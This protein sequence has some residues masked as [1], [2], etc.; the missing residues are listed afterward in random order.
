M[1]VFRS[2]TICMNVRWN[3]HGLLKQEAAAGVLLYESTAQIISL[4]HKGQFPGSMVKCN[5]FF[6]STDISF[7]EIN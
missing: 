6:V 7:L 2:M 5:T 1:M 3:V 4:R